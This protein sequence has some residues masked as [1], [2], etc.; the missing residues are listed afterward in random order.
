MNAYVWLHNKTVLESSLN[1]QVPHRASLAPN[2]PS[3]EPGCTSSNRL[4][5]LGD[6]EAMVQGCKANNRT[7]HGIASLCFH[8]GPGPGLA[9]LEMKAARTLRTYA[10]DRRKALQ[11]EGLS[12]GQ[13]SLLHGW[14]AVVENQA[15]VLDET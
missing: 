11:H 4:L 5:L 14:Q 3:H 13:P 6:C 2:P 7:I 9:H 8:C 15:V 1:C 12:G 10:R